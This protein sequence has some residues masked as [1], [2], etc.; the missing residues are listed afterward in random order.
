MPEAM[1]GIESGWIEIRRVVTEDDD[2]VHVTASDD[3]PM[4]EGL[5][6]L[7]LAKDTWLRTH[8]LRDEPDQP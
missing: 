7:E 6:L 5:G 3:L 8:G 2:Q 4:V 1:M